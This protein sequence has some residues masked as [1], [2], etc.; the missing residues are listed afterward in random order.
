MDKNKKVIGHKCKIHGV[1][2][3]LGGTN[4]AVG[5]M[6]FDNAKM[7]CNKCYEDM[8]DKYCTIEEIFENE[9]EF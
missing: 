3:V 2:K 7:W 4:K 9:K 5:L 8:L 1:T 6:W